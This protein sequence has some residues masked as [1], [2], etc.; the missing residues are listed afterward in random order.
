M[1]ESGSHQAVVLTF[2]ETK[3]P[4]IERG[5]IR[6]IF[7]HRIVFRNNFQ[8]HTYT[9]KGLIKCTMQFFGHLKRQQKC[10]QPNVSCTRFLDN[11]YV[12][13]IAKLCKQSL[14]VG[15]FSLKFLHCLLLLL[16]FGQ[17]TSS[18]ERE[19]PNSW[20]FLTKWS[21]NGFVYL[22]THCAR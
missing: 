22:Q 10:C 6:H 16:R 13:L 1:S 12:Q 19:K 17:K 9:K 11:S 8:T 20:L 18:T 2:C 5:G 4:S 14:F 21:L 7:L 15:C 3:Q